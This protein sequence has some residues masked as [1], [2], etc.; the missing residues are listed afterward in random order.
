MAK[1]VF[2]GGIW[3][4]SDEKKEIE[5]SKGNVQIAANVFQRSLI[6][7][8]D[9]CLSN[10][11]TV[12]NEK[13]IGAYPINYKKMIIYSRT[14]S[15][16]N[17]SQHLDYEVGFYNLPIIKHF[18]R[19]LNSKKYLKTICT[20][21]SDQIF[22]IGY[23]MTFSIVKGL[24]YAKKI[25][26]DIKTCLIVPDLPQF[27]NLGQS[28]G[29]I[30]D[31]FKNMSNSLLYRYIKKLDS[32]AVLTKYMLDELGCKKKYVVI[33][34][35][36]PLSMDDG[37][38]ISDHEE[39]SK[40]KNIVYTG[41]LDI[42]YGI[43]EL[44]DAFSSLSNNDVRL[45]I[46]GRGDGEEYIKSKSKYDNRIIYKG[47]VTNLEAREIQRKSFFLVNP[48]SSKEEY[49]KYSFPSKTMEYM[50]SGRP[51]LM[52]KLAGIPDEYDKY[53]YYIQDSMLN[54]L[55]TML[56]KSD[57]ELS[58]IGEMGRKFVLSEKNSKT[59]ANKILSMLNEL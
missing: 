16:I 31:F 47:A 26:P 43:K 12:V 15:H 53:L 22:V 54:A 58:K 25:N 41:T 50:I 42:K 4:N 5:L 13:F 17:D 36:A 35:L 30:F 49:T 3:M 32:F 1:V 23:S 14:F 20:D 10:P 57:D 52:Y 59:Q 34:G 48:R 38:Y 55:L 9:D 33:E 28:R 18:F 29:M 11:V 24:L 21:D 7:G 6:E 27:M 37:K 44:V 19:Y 46:C 51:V 45:I 39:S 8:L 40:V 2:I 56:E